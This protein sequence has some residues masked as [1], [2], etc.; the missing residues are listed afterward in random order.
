[1][2]SLSY[3]AAK[4][5]FRRDAATINHIRHNNTDDAADAEDDA[6]DDTSQQFTPEQLLSLWNVLI[7][8]GV[9]DASAPPDH[10]SDEWSWDAES[11]VMGEYTGFPLYLKLRDRMCSLHIPVQ[12]H[13]L[14]IQEL[15]DSHDEAA[16]VESQP[17]STLIMFDR[18]GVVQPLGIDTFMPP[19]SVYE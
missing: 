3:A 6:A 12:A 15:V 2:F 5:P 17:R 4:L 8:G 18:P 7:E 16:A 14:L 10:K 1:M 11:M 19:L 9:V 13:N